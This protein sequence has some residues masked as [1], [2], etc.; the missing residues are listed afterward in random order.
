MSR[1]IIARH[2]PSAADPDGWKILTSKAE[3]GKHAIATF[4]PDSVHHE[5]H[6]GNMFSY[7]E[8][9]TLASAAG[10]EVVFV[11]PPAGRRPAHLKINV[12]STKEL[13]ADFFEGGTGAVGAEITNVFN[14]CRF[15]TNAP[16]GKLYEVGS[17][18]AGTQIDFDLGGSSNKAG[19]EVRGESE[20]NL[21]SSEKYRL[22]VTSNEASNLIVIKFDWYEPDE[23]F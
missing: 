19:G 4:G 9:L 11:A 2:I 13:T 20:W 21:N 12:K 6:D 7:S 18:A 10:R 8:R 3:G 23:V 16:I 15:S 22:L 14:R 5:L 17:V 1:I